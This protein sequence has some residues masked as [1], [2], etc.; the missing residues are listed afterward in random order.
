MEFSNFE[1]KLRERVPELRMSS[2]ERQSA[3]QAN[4]EMGAAWCRG[5]ASF[6][7][8]AKRDY[9]LALERFTI[10]RIQYERLIGQHTL[11]EVWIEQIEEH[12]RILKEL[13][14][15][16]SEELSLAIVQAKK[17]QQNEEQIKE[18]REAIQQGRD[19][20][21]EMREKLRA[22]ILEEM[23]REAAEAKE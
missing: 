8:A 11:V 2:V 13:S 12:R 17:V 18:V 15:T 10:W 1:A 3:S 4:F 19:P 22:E 21:A 5:I 23:R 14:G 6:G 7:E 9:E 16:L 20:M